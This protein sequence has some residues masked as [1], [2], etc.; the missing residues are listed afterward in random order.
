LDLKEAGTP[1]GTI[2]KF[3]LKHPK[4]F[5]QMMPIYI[6]KGKGL[7]YDINLLLMFISFIVLILI[8]TYLSWK[9]I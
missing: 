6:Q 3:M 5:L 4:S 2:L 9:Y 7:V 8:T 1:S